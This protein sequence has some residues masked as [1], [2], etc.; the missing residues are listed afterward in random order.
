MASRVPNKLVFDYLIFPIQVNIRDISNLKLLPL[1]FSERWHQGYLYVKTS[2]MLMYVTSVFYHHQLRYTS[3]YKIRYT[4]KIYHSSMCL[5]I[6]DFAH[7]HITIPQGVLLSFPASDLLKS[8]V[9]L[10]VTSVRETESL[11]KR[12]CFSDAFV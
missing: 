3:S 4:T 2:G 5:A 10:S 12:K 11:S 1:L 6:N 7:L 9:L 8:A